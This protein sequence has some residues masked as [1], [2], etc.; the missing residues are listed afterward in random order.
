MEQAKAVEAKNKD[1]IAK[2][3]SDAEGFLKAHFEKDYYQ[4]LK[5]SCEQEKALAKEQYDTRVAQLNKEHEQTLSK[6]T[7]HQEIK[8]EKYVHKN[9]LF[10]VKMDLDKELQRIK[11]RRQLHLSA[12]SPVEPAPSVQ[13]HLRRPGRRNGKI[14]NIHSTAGHS[15]CRT[16]CILPLS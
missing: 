4:P 10:D 1:E 9:R 16:V 12:V 13:I 3:I 11:D 2:L 6:L 8:D 14:I 15:Y 7:D 5:A